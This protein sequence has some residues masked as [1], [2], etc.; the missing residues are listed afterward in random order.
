MTKDKSEYLSVTVYNYFDNP[1]TLELVNEFKF[2][3]WIEQDKK[4]RAYWE[5]PEGKAE[6]ERERI[7][8]EARYK[9]ES[10]FAKRWQWLHNKLASNGCECNHDDCG[11]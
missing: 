9:R 3:S 10:R 4:R 11:Y 2:E 7:A 5:S 1:A 6:L 8:R